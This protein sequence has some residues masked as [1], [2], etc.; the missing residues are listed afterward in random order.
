M[1]AHLE[2]QSTGGSTKHKVTMESSEGNYHD[3]SNSRVASRARSPQRIKS[4]R[5]THHVPKAQV[6]GPQRPARQAR[7]V[8]S[9]P[10]GTTSTS[11]VYV[12]NGAPPKMPRTGLHSLE[13]QIVTLPST[14]SMNLQ[15]PRRAMTENGHA[16]VKQ[17]EDGLKSC[18]SGPV[19]RR[20]VSDSGTGRATRTGGMVEEEKE[21]SDVG[22]TVVEGGKTSGRTSAR[23]MVRSG[24]MYETGVNGPRR[25]ISLK[26]ESRSQWS[27]GDGVGI[28]G[29]SWLGRR[30][31][32]EW[33][34]GVYPRIVY[35][36]DS[37]SG[38][39]D[40]LGG[41]LTGTVLCRMGPDHRVWDVVRR[42][43]KFVVRVVGSFTS[44]VEDVVVYSVVGNGRSHVHC[45]RTGSGFVGVADRAGRVCDEEAGEVVTVC[46]GV[47]GGG[48]EVLAGEVRWRL[49]GEDEV[50]RSG[51]MLM[52]FGYYF[53]LKEA[54][55]VRLFTTTHTP[56]HVR[57]VARRVSDGSIDEAFSASLTYVVVRVAAD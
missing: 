12:A 26:A 1:C 31:L 22:T 23:Y 16:R 52:R 57:L 5:V 54:T 43:Q 3:A 28:R 33:S 24:S 13:D 29:L 47:S 53:F 36:A 49:G 30:K 40:G 45:R 21:V 20:V 11:S 9:T 8:M 42:G 35:A 44:D 41:G 48:R 4:P 55:G 7:R 10:C 6:R 51:A 46:V 2:I 19:A 32:V 25:A 56:E 15:Q 17:L 18:L 50:T 38:S 14:A 39:E 37:T 34:L 27:V